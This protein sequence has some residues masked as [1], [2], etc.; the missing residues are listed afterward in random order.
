[1]FCFVFLTVICQLCRTL[2]SHHN[3]KFRP[4]VLVQR[5]EKKSVFYLENYTIVFNTAKNNWMNKQLKF[6]WTHNCSYIYIY[7][8]KKKEKSFLLCRQTQANWFPCIHAC[9][10]DSREKSSWK[11]QHDQKSCDHVQRTYDLGVFKRFALKTWIRSAVQSAFTT[12]LVDQNT[13]KM[14]IRWTKF[15]MDL[16]WVCNWMGNWTEL[17]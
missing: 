1:M 13:N 2:W 12:I 4:T 11:R 8:L 15:V 3:T 7:V 6:G 16:L 10:S 17:K 9:Y 5:P 14:G